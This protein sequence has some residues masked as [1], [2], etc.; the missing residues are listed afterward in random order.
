MYPNVEFSSSLGEFAGRGIFTK[1]DVPHLSCIGL[2]KLINVVYMHPATYDVISRLKHIGAL[3]NAMEK[4]LRYTAMA[5]DTPSA[6]M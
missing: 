4:L 6:T 5:M 2:E 1:V 3:K